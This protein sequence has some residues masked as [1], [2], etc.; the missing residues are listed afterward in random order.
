MT[1]ESETYRAQ[2]GTNGTTGPWTVPFYFL[3]DADLRVIYT[4]A[5]GVDSTLALTT[6]YSVT[7]AGVPSGGGVTTTAS[8]ASGG[9]ITVLR[10]VELL[11][12]TDYTEGDGFPAETHERALDRL[13]MIAQQQAEVVGR[14]LVYGPA[15]TGVSE[16]PAAAERAGRLLAFNSTTGA[17]Q[18][19]SFTETELASAVAAAYAAGSTADAVTFLPFGTG[20]VSRTVQARL[21]DWASIID[22]GADPTGVADSSAAIAAAL[23]AK[24]HV[25]VPWGNYL[26]NSTI[27][28]GSGQA[29][30]WAVGA[31]FKAGA[32]GMTMLKASVAAYGSELIRPR[33]SGNGKTNVTG[34]DLTNFRVGAVLYKP[35]VQDMEIGMIFRH[36]CFGL[37]VVT[38]AS[39]NCHYPIQVLGNASDMVIQTPAIDNEPGVG[40]D[41]TGIGIDIRY[42]AGSNLG[43]QVV[44][45]YVQGFDVGVKDAGTGTDIDGTYFEDNGTA[46]ISAVAARGGTYTR[47]KHFGPD[48]PACF[49]LRN[50]DAVSTM[51]YTMASGARTVVHD[52]DNTNTNCEY[53]ETGSNAFY[54][55]PID[56]TADTVSK[57]L[58]KKL[59]LQT[60]GTFTPV[61]VGTGAA[62]TGTYTVQSGIW[63]RIGDL[64]QFN[65]SLTWT[66]HTGTANMLV[67]G[68][69]VALIPANFTPTRVFA[70]S[71]DGIP[72][73]GPGKYAYFNGTS[74]AGGI[75]ISLAQESTGGVT[76]LIPIDGS[77]SIHIAGSYRMTA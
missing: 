24:N 76:S 29:I 47:T 52:V 13:T 18:A 45:G 30:E 70:L 27:E 72:W 9:Y 22:Y 42:D 19:S 14:A 15:D 39:T 41:G 67:N 69:P 77:G 12:E 51:L 1:V 34:M 55:V 2:Y 43:V 46:D 57:A 20:A 48:G 33:L 25:W 36:G 49:K 31:Y 5:S 64:V 23:L 50:S 54:N 28:L 11:Q 74:G 4:N 26:I 35:L 65:L 63:T 53:H 68:L 17:A 7:G 8:Y 21:R 38:P 71:I 44:K 6:D 73:T 16:L 56:T 10:D 59:A 37:H 66:A 75:Q 58:M 32:N 3:T 40:G 61:L 62:G 60:Q